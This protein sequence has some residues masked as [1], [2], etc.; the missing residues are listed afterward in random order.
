MKLHYNILWIDDQMEQLLES[1]IKPGIEAYLE[2]LGFDHRIDCYENKEKVEERLKTEKYDLILSDY[3]IEDGGEQGDVLIRNIREGGVFTEVLFYSARPNFVDIA[4][5][6]IWS[7]RLSFFSMTGRNAYKDFTE[8]VIWL[9]GQTV[10]K[11]QELNSIRGLV[12]AQTSGLDNIVE[13]IIAS[14]LSLENED[15]EKLKTYILGIIKESC[16]SNLTSSEKLHKLDC[17]GL[18]KCRIFDADKKSRTINKVLEMK[19]LSSDDP[20][21]D[22]YKNYKEDVLDKR[23]DLAHAKSEVID[24]I[25]YLIISRKDGERPEKFDQEKCIEIRKNL[26]KH[27]LLLGTIREALIPAIAQLA[28]TAPVVDNPS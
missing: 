15:S 4:K 24:G 11:L 18:V 22:F 8:K 1:N 3:N 28:T 5:N 23:N 12:M 17:H 9:I 7:D 26:K 6:T 21:K 19:N 14:F 20:F 10:S 25:E 16:Q 2:G 27:A 13:E